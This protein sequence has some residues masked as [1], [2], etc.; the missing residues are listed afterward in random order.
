MNYRVGKIDA[1]VNQLD[2]AIKLFLNHKAYVQQHK[3]KALNETNGWQA[4][5]SEILL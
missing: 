2:W 4:G 5:G 3:A 1:A